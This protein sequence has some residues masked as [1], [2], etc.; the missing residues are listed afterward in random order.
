MTRLQRRTRTELLCILNWKVDNNCRK[1]NLN[2]AVLD[3]KS[4]LNDSNKALDI[5]PKYT[6]ALHRRGKAKLELKEYEDAITDFQKILE[7]EPN[8]QEV[9]IERLQRAKCIWVGQCGPHGRE[10]RVK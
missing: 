9:K 2:V 10:N 4:A 1:S 3:W 8:N 7:I 5:D 6:K